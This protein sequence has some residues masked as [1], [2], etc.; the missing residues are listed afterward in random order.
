MIFDMFHLLILKFFTIIFIAQCASFE[1]NLW[2]IFYAK[3][4]SDPPWSVVRRWTIFSFFF[5]FSGFWDYQN[6]N[7]LFF[8]P[9][10]TLSLFTQSCRFDVPTCSSFLSPFFWKESYHPIENEKGWTQFGDSFRSSSRPSLSCKIF[11]IGMFFEHKGF[12]IVVLSLYYH[13]YHYFT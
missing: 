4:D 8:L 3:N 5:S 12:N 7:E 9:H 13:Y 11:E 2:S 10:K 6:Y 1:N